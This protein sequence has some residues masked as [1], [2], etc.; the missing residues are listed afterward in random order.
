MSMDLAAIR[1]AY[2]EEL[3]T[4]V[5]LRSEALAR[6]FATVPREHF[7]GTGPW[8]PMPRPA[9]YTTR[10]DANPAHLYRDVLVAIDAQRLLNNGHPSSIAAWLDAL[11]LQ[12]GERV[13]HI[14]C[15]VGYYTAVLAETVGAQGF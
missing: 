13:V 1:L 10:V 4:R 7:L 9:A 5:G 6:A 8:Q 15:G 12:S 11:D 2:A 3:R 14:G